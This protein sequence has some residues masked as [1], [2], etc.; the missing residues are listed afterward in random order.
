M[1][2][3]ADDGTVTK[4]FIF[5]WGKFWGTRGIRKSTKEGKVYF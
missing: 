4:K 1:V 3:K 5:F 2:N